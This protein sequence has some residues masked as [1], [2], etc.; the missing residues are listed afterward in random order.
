MTMTRY[1]ITGASGQLGRLTVHELLARGVPA[2]D[3]RR[4]RAHSRQGR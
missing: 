1:A 4:D 2:S 3:D